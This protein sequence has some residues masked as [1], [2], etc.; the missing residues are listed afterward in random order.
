MHLS[1]I[2]SVAMHPHVEFL[3]ME[4]VFKHP[5]K[6]HGTLA[7]TAAT[8]TKTLHICTFNEENNRPARAF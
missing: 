8:A 5:K 7:T 2:N 1:T 3:I 4:A 6:T